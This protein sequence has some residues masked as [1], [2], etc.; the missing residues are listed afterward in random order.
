MVRTEDNNHT[1]GTS[2]RNSIYIYKIIITS[3]ALGA[4]FALHVLSNHDNEY[5][6]DQQQHEDAANGHCEHGRVL[7]QLG[8]RSRARGRRDQRRC[9]H[10]RAY[11][12]FSFFLLLK[13]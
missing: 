7:T 3:P 2:T 12:A 6:E 9:Y 5:D 11:S 4:A 8:A 13:L 1:T 10:S